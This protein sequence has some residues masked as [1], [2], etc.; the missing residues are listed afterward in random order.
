MKALRGCIERLAETKPGSHDIAGLSN[1]FHVL[2][3]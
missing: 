3:L 1:N 2:Y